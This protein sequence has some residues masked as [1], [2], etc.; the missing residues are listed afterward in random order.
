VK[1]IPIP[2]RT[3]LYEATRVY[4]GFLILQARK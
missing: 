4:I 3:R 1:R 2:R